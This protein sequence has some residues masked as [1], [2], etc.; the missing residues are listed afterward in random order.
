MRTCKNMTDHASTSNDGDAMEAYNEHITV[1]GRIE[2]LV[3]EMLL[4]YEATGC[5]YFKSQAS[6]WSQ[7]VWMLLDSKRREWQVTYAGNPHGCVPFT[8]GIALSEWAGV[9]PC[10]S[11]DT[12]M[13]TGKLSND[14]NNV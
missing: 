8:K 10:A 5:E 2:R 13:A 3:M 7:W 14:L 11:S 9:T 12:S 6:A 4:L 1:G